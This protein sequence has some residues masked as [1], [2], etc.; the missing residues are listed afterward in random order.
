MTFCLNLMKLQRCLQEHRG[1]TAQQSR[2]TGRR[3]ERNNTEGRISQMKQSVNRQEPLPGRGVPSCCQGEEEREGRPG[4]REGPKKVKRPHERR[5]GA[6]DQARKRQQ[7][8]KKGNGE[9]RKKKERVIRLFKEN[10][11]TE[12]TENQ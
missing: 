8:I 11:T 12:R 9:T 2:L 1:T 5:A 7:V 3:R 4:S 6:R 10:N